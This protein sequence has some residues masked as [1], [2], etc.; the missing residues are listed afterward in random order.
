MKSKMLLLALTAVVLLGAAPVSFAQDP[1]AQDSILL[2][3]SR[4]TVSGDDS[5]FVVE[6]YYKGDSGNVVGTALGYTWDRSSVPITLDSAVIPQTIDDAFD[7]VASGYFAGSLA[8]SNDSGIFV[9][10]LARLFQSGFALDGSAVLLATYYFTVTGW[11]GADEI[12][13]DTMLSD[14]LT[15]AVNQEINLF[16]EGATLTVFA[17]MPERFAFQDPTDAGD[18][19]NSVLPTDY[20]LEQNYPNPF[21]PTTTIQFALPVQSEVKLDVY[22]LL[23]QKVRTLKNENMDAGAYEVEWDGTNDGGAKVAS[24]VYFYKLETSDFVDTK[25]MMMV[26]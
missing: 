14:N 23:G 16:Y 1:G 4:P 19:D 20:A 7:F 8:Q 21:N 17:D 13:L 11:S 24:G 26:K 15:A 9:C 10:T 5:S 6:M 18:A 12:V 22:N 2:V 3:A 25:K